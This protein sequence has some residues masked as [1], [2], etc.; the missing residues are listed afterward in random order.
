MNVHGRILLLGC[1]ILSIIVF[2]YLFWQK[3]IAQSEAAKYRTEKVRQGDVVATVSAN[4]TLNPVTLVSIGSQITGKV[5]KLYADFNDHV[6]AGQ[7]LLELDPALLKGQV[8]ES[9]AAF[10]K[11]K[12]DLDLARANVECGKKLHQQKYISDQDWDQ[13]SQTVEAADAVLEDAQAKLANDR[14]S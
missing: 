7:I 3:N 6:S 8:A 13:L 4:G 11:A 2:S 1:S 12:A 9:L 5:L 10:N 14:T